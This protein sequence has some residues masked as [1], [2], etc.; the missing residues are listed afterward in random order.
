MK[1]LLLLLTV[2]CLAGCFDRTDANIEKY[3]KCAKAGMVMHLSRGGS[4]ECYPPQVLE[5]MKNGRE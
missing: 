2:L 4:Y 3:Q 1:Q 5:D